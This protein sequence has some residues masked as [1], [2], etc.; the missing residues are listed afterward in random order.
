MKNTL[1]LL[2]II[3]HIAILNAKIVINTHCSKEQSFETKLTI[4]INSNTL[5][6]SEDAVIDNV[7]GYVDIPE[8]NYYLKTDHNIYHLK[9]EVERDH[10]DN[11]NKFTF[12]IY[13]NSQKSITIEELYNLK[14]SK[15][16][17]FIQKINLEKNNSINSFKTTTN[18]LNIHFDQKLFTEEYLKCKEK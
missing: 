14:D 13:N 16:L 18:K 8:D 3:S 6:L 15:N 9:G 1:F 17:L 11:I 5:N 2:L 4:F 12:T 7:G 10:I